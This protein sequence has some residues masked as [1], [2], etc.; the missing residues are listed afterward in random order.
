MCKTSDGGY[1]LA[2]YTNSFGAGNV[3]LWLI[4]VN[5]TGDMQWNKT[6]GGAGQDQAFEVIQTQDGGYVMVGSTN[7]SGA[8][9]LT[10]GFLKQIQL[11][12]CSGTKPLEEA[13]PILDIP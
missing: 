13:V 9:G 6:Y 5:A 10:F 8:G 3:D 2:G 12:T 4:K 7:S 11:V 1:A